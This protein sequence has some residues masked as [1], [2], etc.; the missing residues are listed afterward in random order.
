MRTRAYTRRAGVALVMALV[1]MAALAVI[2][3]V[4][5][6]Q[7]VA[8]RQV[9][10]QRHRQ[11]QAEWLARAGVELAAARLLNDPS[12]FSEEKQ[13]LLPDAKVH[14]AVEKTGQDLYTVKVE[15]VLGAKEE[16]PMART[17]N[18]GFRRVAN[19]GEVRLQALP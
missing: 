1:A 9:L 7:I 3:S 5:T 18:R 6:R 8:Q 10:D 12:P 15:A 13:D 11:L 4:V 17:A 16:T 14:I 19:D 2:L